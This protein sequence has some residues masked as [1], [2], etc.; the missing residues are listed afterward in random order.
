MRPWYENLSKGEML[1]WGGSE[2][3]VIEPWNGSY[4]RV[5][6]LCFSER[7]PMRFD[8]NE[9][10]LGCEPM[11]DDNKRR[12]VQRVILEGGRL[13]L[14]EGSVGPDV[15]KEHAYSGWSKDHLSN[16]HFNKADEAASFLIP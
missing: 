2:V 11:V 6:G 12:A 1:L 10:E 5:W 9:L 4:L 3:F 16:K 15:T 13:T 8:V 14:P 7:G